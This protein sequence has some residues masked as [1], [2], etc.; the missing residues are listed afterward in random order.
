MTNKKIE[1]KTTLSHSRT[2]NLGNYNSVHYGIQR[3]FLQPLDEVLETRNIID[4]VDNELKKRYEEAPVIKEKIQEPSKPIFKTDKKNKN[5]FKTNC[6]Y[7]G[8]CNKE[9][10]MKKNDEGKWKPLNPDGSPHRCK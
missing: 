10:T 2:I 7:K 8:G 3:E 4:F 1:L 5:E 6:T 9:I